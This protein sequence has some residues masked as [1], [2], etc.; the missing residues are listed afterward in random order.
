MLV[1]PGANYRLEVL[2]SS[3]AIMEQIAIELPFGLQYDDSRTRVVNDFCDEVPTNIGGEVLNL[4][5][6][7]VWHLVA[8]QINLLIPGLGQMPIQTVQ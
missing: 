1:L 6:I 7:L 2:D 8:D 3:C 5:L 4:K